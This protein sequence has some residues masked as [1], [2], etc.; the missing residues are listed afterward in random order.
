M[1]CGGIDVGGTKME[2]QLFDEGMR[3]VTSRRSPT[4]HEDFDAFIAGLAEEARWLITQSGRAG[5][6]IGIGLPGIVDPVSGASTASNIPTSGRDIAAALQASVGRSFVYGNDCASFALSEANGGAGEG[7]RCVV[8]L[9]IGTGV[10]AGISINGTTPPRH[11]QLAVEIGHVGV[12]TRTLRR[13]GLPEWRCGCGRSACFEPYMS[14]KGIA[15]LARWKL[16]EEVSAAEIAT[17]PRG[18]EVLDIWADVTAEALDTLQLL[19]DPDCIT[20]GGGVSRLPDLTARL[21]QALLRLRLGTSR[22]PALR[23]AQHGD[24]SGGRGMALIALRAAS[25][26]SA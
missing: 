4:R 2:A 8:G 9:I 14:G 15:N 22:P 20:F 24:S 7:F 19:F 1:I 5:L 26:P 16:G 11:N 12:P 23:I 3:L 17:H 21:E 13:H 6:P 25:S 10:G 18:G